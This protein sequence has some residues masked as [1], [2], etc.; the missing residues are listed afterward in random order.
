MTS[1]HFFFMTHIVNF[2]SERRYEPHYESHYD[3]HCDL[4]VSERRYE[5]HH[6][7]PYDFVSERRCERHVSSVCICMLLIRLHIYYIH[8]CVYIYVYICIYIYIHTHTLT[9]IFFVTQRNI[10]ANLPRTA[11]GS[12]RFLS[13]AFRSR[14]HMIRIRNYVGVIYV[15]CMC[16]LPA[17]MSI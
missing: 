11:H 13:G 8:L 16:V 2:V 9:L 3:F 17:G 7:C 12:L 6:E 14:K 5:S 1:C 10:Q 15:S 4:A